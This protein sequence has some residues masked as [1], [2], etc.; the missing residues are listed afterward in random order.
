[1]VDNVTSVNTPTFIVNEAVALRNITAFQSHCN[2][3]GLALRPHIKTHKSIHFAKAQMAA[4][5]IGITCQKISEAEAMINS[6]I[7]DILITFNIIGPE[8]LGRLRALSSRLAALSVVADNAEVIQGLGQAFEAAPLPLTILV[9]CDTG[10]GRC[11]VQTPKAALELAEK[12]SHISGLIFGGLMTYPAANGSKDAAQFMR[13]TKQLLGAKGIVCPVI[14]S[15]GSPDMWNAI[16][17]GI[18]T[19]YRIGTYIY[20]DRSLVQRGTCTWDECAGHVLATVVS[21]PTPD[22][23]IIDAGSKVLTS[24]LLGFSDYGHVV[25]KP[26]IKI[27]GLSEE[28]GVLAV[29]PERQLV[30]GERIR[31]VPNHVCVVSNMFDDIWIEDENGSLAEL[32]ID[33]RG[34]VI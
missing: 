27:V 4:G 2:E 8:K 23:A 34:C 22:R 32:Q 17:A 15:G 13:D 6:G 30:I 20:N 16:T 11:G 31:I 5:A 7:N 33:A 21:I 10:A 29:T 3:V 14:S 12:I 9:E 19:E 26:E 1:M 25:G 18:I 28:H 24:D